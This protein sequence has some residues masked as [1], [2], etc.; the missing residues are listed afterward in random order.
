MSSRDGS[1]PKSVA[2]RK[3]LEA[4]QPLAPRGQAR[5]VGQFLD[6]RQCKVLKVHELFLD[7]PKRLRTAAVAAILAFRLPHLRLDLRGLAGE[8]PLPTRRVVAD[9]RRLHEQLFPPPRRPQ[10][11]RHNRRILVR[12]RK[13]LL[14]RIQR[15]VR[16]LYS[17]GTLCYEALLLL[18]RYLGP[19]YSNS[20]RPI[21]APT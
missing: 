10:R 3:A 19:V 13:R 2:G 17:G 6:D 1:I 15:F 8:T 4:I 9:D 20:T 16:G 12:L 14:L 18:E 5:P 7:L 21:P 11:T